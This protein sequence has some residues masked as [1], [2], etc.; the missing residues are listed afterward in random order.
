[1]NCTYCGY[2]S[3]RVVNDY[4]GA[5]YATCPRCYRST[6]FYRISPSIPPIEKRAAPSQTGITTPRDI[7]PGSL[8]E[9]SPAE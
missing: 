2:N 9:P 7:G 1:M 8:L 3:L 4:T 6:P 5:P